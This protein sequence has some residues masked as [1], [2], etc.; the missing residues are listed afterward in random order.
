[1]IDGVKKT[2]TSKDFGE[3]VFDEFELTIK[4]LVG[5]ST[6]NTTYKIESCERIIKTD[7][8]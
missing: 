1:M 2:Y 7:L 8:V 5:V 4:K 6:I 3:I